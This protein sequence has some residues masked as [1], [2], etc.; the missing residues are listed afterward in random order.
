MTRFVVLAL[1]LTGCAQP[2]RTDAPYRSCVAYY[3]Q[4]FGFTPDEAKAECEDF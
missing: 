1:L 4:V 2:E 3:H